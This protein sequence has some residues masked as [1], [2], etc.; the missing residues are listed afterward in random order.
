MKIFL[1]PYVAFFWF[2]DNM[3]SPDYTLK[4]DE[5]FTYNLSLTPHSLDSS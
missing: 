3:C 1:F 4:L 2:T 5:G